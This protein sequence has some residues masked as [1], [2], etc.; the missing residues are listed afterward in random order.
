VVRNAT[1]LIAMLVDIHAGCRI[2]DHTHVVKCFSPHDRSTPITRFPCS[3]QQ[4]EEFEDFYEE[5]WDELSNFGKLE[6]LHVCDNLGDHMVG[7]VYAKFFDEEDADSAL[8]GL[9]GR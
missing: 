9:D 6:E 8:K 7:N 2:T 1:M 5:V 3:P 4:Q